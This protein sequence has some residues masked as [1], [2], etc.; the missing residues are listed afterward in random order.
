MVSLVVLIAAVIFGFVALFLIV[1]L[2]LVLFIGVNNGICNV[3]DANFGCEPLVNPHFIA[4]T[5]LNFYISQKVDPVRYV[6]VACIIPNTTASQPPQSEFKNIGRL[7]QSVP[8]SQCQ[9]TGPQTS[10]F[11]TYSTVHTSCSTV[12]TN[13]ILINVP[14]YDSSGNPMSLARN[15]SVNGTIWVNYS[16]SSGAGP[17]IVEKLAGFYGKNKAGTI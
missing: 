8:E 13:L 1:G 15:A 16:T 4:N 11:G 3:Y 5:G 12:Y 7:N 9:S 17:Y 10:R 6:Q 2:G 14:C